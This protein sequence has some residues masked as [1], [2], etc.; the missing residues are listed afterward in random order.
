MRNYP[1]SE[2]KFNEFLYQVRE[3]AISAFENQEYQFEELVTSLKIKRDISRNP[4]FDTMF[5][6]QNV[7][8]SDI[9][10]RES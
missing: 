8:A 2:T 1:T 5:V 6:L 9:K 10:N 7:D 4:I 3:N